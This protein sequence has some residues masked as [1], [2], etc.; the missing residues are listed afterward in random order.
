MFA[1]ADLLLLPEWLAPCTDYFSDTLS[2]KLTTPSF[3]SCFVF[4][5]VQESVKLSF[6]AQYGRNLNFAYDFLYGD[7][8]GYCGIC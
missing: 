2:K 4:I 1:L 5:Q 8:A 7:F 3:V 6:L